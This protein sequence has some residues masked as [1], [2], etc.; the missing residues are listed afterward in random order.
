MPYEINWEKNGLVVRFSGIFDFETNKNASCEVYE[1]SRCDSLKYVIWDATG[2]SES[3]MSENDFAIL[4]MQDLTGSI[5]LPELKLALV[6]QG[7]DLL[8]LFKNHTVSYNTRKTGWD[9]M[10]SDNMEDIRSWINS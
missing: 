8:R 3:V 10:V 9:F 6:A 5:R 1:D 2:I 7:K 4:A